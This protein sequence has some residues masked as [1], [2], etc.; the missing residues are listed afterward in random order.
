MARWH[1][2]RHYLIWVL[3]NLVNLMAL[4]HVL[5]QSGFIMKFPPNGHFYSIKRLRATYVVLF[6]ILPKM[7]SINSECSWF[8]NPGE[9]TCT[10]LFQNWNPKQDSLHELVS[11]YS[12]QD[13]ANLSPVVQRASKFKL[14]C[15]LLI[16][17]FGWGAWIV[18]IDQPTSRSGMGS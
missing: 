13:C 12:R 8:T 10:T 11:I 2:N 16:W 5:C 15:L 6:W 17:P 1:S 7:I 9:H 14:E 4:C 18:C 3:L